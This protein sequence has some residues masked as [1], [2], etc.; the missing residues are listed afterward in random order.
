MSE[1]DLDLLDPL[2]FNGSDYVPERDNERLRGQILRVFQATEGERWLTLGE[3]QQIT[4]DPQASISAQLRHLRKD[5][6][7]G[8]V[9][10]KR[11]RDGIPGWYEYR[12]LS[13]DVE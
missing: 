13:K 7:G 3:L 9:I 12:R 5:R 4:G 1:R 10:E 11:L 6:F 8:H 2:R